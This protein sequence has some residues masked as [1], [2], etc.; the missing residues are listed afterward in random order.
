MALNNEIEIPQDILDVIT[1]QHGELR[2]SHD[3]IR[4]YR[5]LEKESK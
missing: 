4:K 1:R 5:D 2:L 3:R